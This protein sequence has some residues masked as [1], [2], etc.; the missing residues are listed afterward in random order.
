MTMVQ[1]VDRDRSGSIDAYELQS[2]LSQG[3]WRPFSLRAAQLMIAIF[4]TDR[5]GTIG[6]LLSR[7]VC[8]F[9]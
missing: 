3:G 1:A 9:E 6:T 8:L 5:S 2:A 4:D 7:A